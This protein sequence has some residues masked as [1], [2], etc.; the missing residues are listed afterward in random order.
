[1]SSLFDMS[2]LYRDELYRDELDRDELDRRLKA[3]LESPDTDVDAGRW[4]DFLRLVSEYPDYKERPAEDRVRIARNFA[5]R[6]QVVRAYRAELE[7]GLFPFFL[8]RPKDDTPS[9]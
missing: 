6:D 7:Q 5:I 2:D 3:A 1:M 4:R 8:R 9:L